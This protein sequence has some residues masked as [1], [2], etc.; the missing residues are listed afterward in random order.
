MGECEDC[1]E[2][3]ADKYKVCLTCLKKRQQANKNESQKDVIKALSAINNNLYCLRRQMQVA[4][5]ETFEL[6]IEW[7]PKRKDFVEVKTKK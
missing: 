2:K 6:R 3:I 4:L 1:G 5:R 7:D